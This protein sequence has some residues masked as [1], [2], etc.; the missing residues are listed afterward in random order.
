MHLRLLIRAQDPSSHGR[1][2]GEAHNVPDL[3]NKT[4]G[5]GELKSLNAVRLETQSSPCT[6][7]GRTTDTGPSA[8]G[9]LEASRG[10]SERAW[11]TVWVTKLRSSSSLPPQMRNNRHRVTS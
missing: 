9:T 2:H 1:R 5:R 8:H 6:T 4:R 10:G 7:E 3:L 11:S